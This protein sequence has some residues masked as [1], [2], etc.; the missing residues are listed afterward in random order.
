MVS[1]CLPE[2]GHKIVRKAVVIDSNREDIEIGKL[3]HALEKLRGEGDNRDPLWLN[4]ENEDRA[5]FKKNKVFISLGMNCGPAIQFEKKKLVEAFFPFDWCVSEFSSIYKALETD[6]K[7]FLALENLVVTERPASSVNHK[8]FD[9]NYRINFVHDFKTDGKVLD[10]YKRVRDKYYRRIDRFYRVL[11]SKKHIYFFRTNIKKNE[12]IK[13]NYLIQK[14]FP[15][16]K[17]TLVVIN[18]SAEFKRPWAVK[19][20]K[21]IQH[22]FV[23]DA[24]SAIVRDFK[25]RQDWDNVFKKLKL[26]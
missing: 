17:Y 22:F 10:D 20:M 24:H 7:D 8:A 1:V 9:T 6:F 21:N 15:E 5:E 11:K 26:V 19:N 2:T 18:D 12:A 16:L 13:L 3:Y 25:S 23:K 4:A 14:K